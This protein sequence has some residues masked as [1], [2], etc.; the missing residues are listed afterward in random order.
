[1]PEKRLV[2]VSEDVLPEVILK[3][4]EAKKLLAQGKCRTSTDA[5]KA[6]DVSRSA[7][8]KYKDSVHV[9]TER[10][11]GRVVTYYF[12]LF[13]RAGVLSEILAHFY[14]VGANVLTINQNIPIE[15][16]ATATV[17]VRF[18]EEGTSPEAVCEELKKTDGVSKVKIIVGSSD[19]TAVR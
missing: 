12:T 17:T 8:Y 11:S 2:I 9:Y 6:V 10:L 19:A 15:S 7:Y 18:D 3:V 14:E 5:C 13:D 1:M 16:V 4:L